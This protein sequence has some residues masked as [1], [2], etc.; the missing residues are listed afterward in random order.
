MVSLILKFRFFANN[1]GV[2]PDAE[3]LF[4]FDC[5]HAALSLVA[6]TFL[7]WL[8]M[9]AAASVKKDVLFRN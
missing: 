7:A 8:L 6:K 2:E 5:G 9:G 3:L 4:K 1:K